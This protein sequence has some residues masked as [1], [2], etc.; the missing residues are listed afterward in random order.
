D[1][2]FEMVERWQKKSLWADDEE[3]IIVDGEKG[4]TKREYSPIAGAYYAARLAVLEY[5]HS[6]RACARV[7]CIRD[8]SGEYWAPLG[9]WV[10]REASHAA[11]S[12]EPKRFGTLSEA[13]TAACTALDTSFWVTKMGL[14]K[15][16]RQQKTLFDF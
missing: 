16:I 4:K 12:K 7:I 14:L 5:L 11:L 13:V 8:I 3:T 2:R 9:V 10:I 1:W 15:D 6:R